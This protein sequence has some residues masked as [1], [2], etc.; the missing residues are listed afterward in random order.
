VTKIEERLEQDV[1]IAS[2]SRE[3]LELGVLRLLKS[4]I[5]NVRIDAM[6][7][8]TEEE[9][10]KVI[11]REAKK[12]QESITLYEQGNRPDLKEQEV[13]ELK[14][15]EKYLPAQLSIDEIQAIIAKVKASL[16]EGVA[17]GQLMGA[18]MKEIAGRAD[19]SVVQRLVKESMG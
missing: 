3:A 8:L 13:A 11:Q 19:G 1:L 14:I 7:D 9:V 18:V 2:K 4:A 6:K 12:R 16:G 17:F 5:K 15:I 10:I